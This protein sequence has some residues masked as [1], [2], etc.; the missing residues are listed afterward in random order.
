MHILYQF[1]GP[2]YKYKKGRTIIDSF[3][4]CIRNLTVIL[5]RHFLEK[6]NALSGDAMKYV[7]I[8]DITRGIK[9][10]VAIC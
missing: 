10:K 1:I 9:D 2:H 5:R 6:Q 7:T 3:C 8:E 4:L